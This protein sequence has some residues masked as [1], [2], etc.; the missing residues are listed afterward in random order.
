MPIRFLWQL[1]FTFTFDKKSCAHC[2]KKIIGEQLCKWN[3]F[4]LINKQR[5]LDKYGLDPLMAGV[6]IGHK[7]SALDEMEYQLGLMCSWV[8]RE[9]KGEFESKVET[10]KKHKVDFRLAEPMCHVFGEYA[11]K[12]RNRAKGLYFLKQAMLEHPE[13][14]TGPKKKGRIF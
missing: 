1:I 2:T 4:I 5:E 6:A 3:G 12:H 9:E 7:G 13:D 14:Y 8:V 10:Y 11:A